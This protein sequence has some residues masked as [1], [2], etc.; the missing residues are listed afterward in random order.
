MTFVDRSVGLVRKAV[1]II[2]KKPLARAADVA[3]GVLRNVESEDFSPHARVLRSLELASRA[4]LK[5]LGK[6]VP[7]DVQ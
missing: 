2:G 4:E 3:A 5:A 6:L 7:D 1:A